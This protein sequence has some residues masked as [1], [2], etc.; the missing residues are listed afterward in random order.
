M[1]QS[2]KI[3]EPKAVR[4]TDGIQT[5]KYHMMIEDTVFIQAAHYQKPTR[6]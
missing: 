1:W 3:Q 2:S 5:P 6:K 4:K